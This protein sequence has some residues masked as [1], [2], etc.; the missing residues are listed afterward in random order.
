MTMKTFDWEYLKTERS[1]QY[2]K[3]LYGNHDK[4]LSE[5]EFVVAVQSLKEFRKGTSYK[6][7]PSHLRRNYRNLVKRFGF[8]THPLTQ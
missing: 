5:E 8:F 3:W 2:Y 4:Q 6:Y 7:S 1:P